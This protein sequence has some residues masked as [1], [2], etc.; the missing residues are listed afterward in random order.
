MF[1]TSKKSNDIGQVETVIGQNT[2]F[3]GTVVAKGSIRIDGELDGEIIIEGDAVVGEAGKITAQIKARNAV[4]AGTLNGNVDVGD[5]LEILPT[6]KLYGDIKVGTL[7]ISEGA[8][9]KGVCEMHR[10]DAN[11]QNS[12]KTT[13]S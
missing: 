11:K 5:K 2:K 9:F 4:V 6:G 10:D 1:G 8:V 12:V 3:K 13:K 7:S